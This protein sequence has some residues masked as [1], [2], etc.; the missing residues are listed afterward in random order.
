[1][2]I[3][4]LYERSLDHYQAFLGETRV[5]HPSIPILYFGDLK[6][7]QRSPLKIVTVGLNPSYAEFSEK[8]F[9]ISDGATCNPVDLEN[10][11]CKYFRVNPYSKWFNRSFERLLQAFEASFYGDYYPRNKIPDWWAPRKNVAIH[12]D[13]GTPLATNPTW[14][15]LPKVLTLKL[16]S[17]GFAL[18]RDLI[19]L[20]EPHLILISVAKSHLSLL[21]S[22]NWQSFSPFELTEVRHELKIADFGKSKIVW[23]QSQV[24]PFFHVKE[25]Q[26]FV[27]AR[28]ILREARI[29]L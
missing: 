2:D 4:S 24:T 21:G 29:K 20:I 16:Q 14:S 22:L 25:E 26:M 18:W 6:R 27:T 8:R 17:N 1:M 19:T 11:L 28:T 15:K 9:D 3:N 13:I 12:T 10:E 5:M 7:F 23:G